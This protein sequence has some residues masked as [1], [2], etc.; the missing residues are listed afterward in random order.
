[1]PA[2]LPCPDRLDYGLRRSD[3]WGSCLTST[4]GPAHRM[5]LTLEK[6][7]G[8]H[9]TPGWR[10]R[11]RLNENSRAWPAPP[12]PATAEERAMPAI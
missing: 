10:R 7:R 4:H 2:M 9:P 12:N 3:R 5:W 6:V 11:H 8:T 1:M